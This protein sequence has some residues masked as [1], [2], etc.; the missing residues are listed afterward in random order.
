MPRQCDAEADCVAVI[1]QSPGDSPKT[2]CLLGLLHQQ[3]AGEFP[4][5]YDVRRRLLCHGSQRSPAM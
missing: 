2:R 5:G 3:L 1:A 4:V